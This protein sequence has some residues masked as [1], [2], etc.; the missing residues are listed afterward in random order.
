MD[1]I[2]LINDFQ[3][4]L[5]NT[6]INATEKESVELDDQKDYIV[7]LLQDFSNLHL[8]PEFEDEIEDYYQEKIKYH[9]SK[10]DY[11]KVKN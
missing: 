4:M 11:L 7:H 2:E 8:K 10:R 9:K 3:K 1:K 5:Q 6:G